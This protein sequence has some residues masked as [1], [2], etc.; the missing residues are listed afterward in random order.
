[1]NHFYIDNTPLTYKSLESDVFKVSSVSK[2]YTVEMTDE[3]IKETL[4]KT[5]KPGNIAVIDGNVFSLYFSDITEAA[6]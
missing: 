4:K 3:S 6:V 1:M 5:Y 2:E